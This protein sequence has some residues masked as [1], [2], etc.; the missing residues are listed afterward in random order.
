MVGE[1]TEVAFAIG[2]CSSWVVVEGGGVVMTALG[3]LYIAVLCTTLSSVSY[4]DSVDS[5]A[6]QGDKHG[7]NLHITTGKALIPGIA[8]SST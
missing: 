8:D 5:G 2:I 3:V 4:T 7:N 1:G 6:P